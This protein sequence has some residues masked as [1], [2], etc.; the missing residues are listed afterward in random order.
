MK[1]C[2]NLY[3]DCQFLATCLESIKEYVDEIIIAD[4][5]YELYYRQ[6]KQAYP[7]AQPWSTDGSLQ[8][9]ESLDGLPAVRILRCTKPWLNQTVKRNALLDAV[10]PGE[11]FL[12]IDADEMLTGDIDEAFTEITESGC[13]LGRI[14]LVNVGLATDRMVYYW[15]PRLFLKMPG[16]H[17]DFTHWQLR[18]KAN[19]IIEN[20][21]PVWWTSSCAMIHFKVFKTRS[22]LQPHREY[23]DQLGYRGWLEPNREEVEAPK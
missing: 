22:R 6:F 5:A 23:M 21:Y 18:D 13:V 19:R 16:M 15:H 7:Q 4:G 8:I 3:N 17:Y 1:A 11:W 20:T 10:H 9:I 14:P 2:I 12:I